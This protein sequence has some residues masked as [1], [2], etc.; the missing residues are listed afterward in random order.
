[1]V[2]FVSY[3]GSWPCYCRGEV[4]LKIDGKEVSLGACLTSCGSVSF[5]DD[6]IEE[7]FKGPWLVELPDELEQYREE[8]EECIDENIPYGCCGGCI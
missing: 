2:E 6:W 4:I 3:D 1:M 5:G 8:I 7:I